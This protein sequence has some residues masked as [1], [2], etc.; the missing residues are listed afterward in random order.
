MFGF[1]K[2]NRIGIIPWAPLSG[3]DLA[4]PLGTETSR[5]D[6]TKGTVFERKPSEADETIINRVGELATKKRCQ[7]G[8]D[9]TRMGRSKGR[10]P[11]RGYQR[12]RAAQ[13]K[14][15]D[16]DHVDTG[17]SEL[18]RRTVRV[19]RF[20]LSCLSFTLTYRYVP[21]PVRGHQ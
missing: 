9:R 18:F 1:C 20:S 2:F 7:N 5:V 15:R 12:C 3:G 17:G 4:R 19:L 8:P 11:D 14:Y 21:K 10:E 13:G 16:R 6:S